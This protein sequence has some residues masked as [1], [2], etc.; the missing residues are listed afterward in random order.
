MEDVQVAIVGAGLVGLATARAIVRRYPNHRVVVL[1]KE[2]EVA[3][4]QSGHNSGVIHAG[5]YYQPGSLRARLCLKGRLML[6][7]YCEQHG[8]HYERCGKVVVATD[9]SERERL[10]NLAHRALQNGIHVRPLGPGELREYEPHASGVAALHSPETGIADYKGLARSLRDELVKSGARIVTGARLTGLSRRA[11]EQ[12]L[13]TTA[14]DVR[15]RWVI[16]CAGLYADEVARTCG[17]DPQVRIVPFRGEYYDLKPER[18]SLVRNLIYPVPDPRFPFLGVH[19]TRMVGGGVEAGP[20]A[21][22]A[23]AREGY[24]RHNVNVGELAN[25][26]RYPGFWRLAARYPTVGAYEMYRSL[27][28]NEF[29]RSLQR[30]V[31]EITSADL[32]PGGSGVR[33]Q[34][35][36]PNGRILDDF[37]IHESAKALH[38]LNAPSPAATACLAIGE[39]LS[40]LAA[41]NFSWQ[42]PAAPV[43]LSS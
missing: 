19:L 3:T 13:H 42:S 22:L 24:K 4:H 25:T 2:A 8:V 35:L 33:A 32:V 31:P 30:L 29:T 39:H 16:T 36:D 6:E 12:V 27:V 11:D 43:G 41:H 23:F 15:A 1:D 21:V 37:A 34:A 17:V 40:Q 20:N 26:L 9:E 7:Q 14:G 5:L 10:L 38:V 28:K 18:Q